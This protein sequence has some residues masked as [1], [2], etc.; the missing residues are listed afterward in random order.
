MIIMV[1]GGNINDF[2]KNMEVFR[3]PL[4]PAPPLQLRRGDRKRLETIIRK[5][6][7]P[8]RAVF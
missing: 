5:L 1:W 3:M 6:T 2:Y 8:Q 7:S 4:Q